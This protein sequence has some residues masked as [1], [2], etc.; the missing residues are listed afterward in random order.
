MPIFPL[1]ALALL[2][3]DGMTASR[4]AVIREAPDFALTTQDNQTLRRADLQGKVLL[5]S[6]VF[7]T[8][9]GT[10]PATTH[11]M[12]QVQDELQRQ[13]LLQEPR[14]HLVSITL[15][16]Q[17]DTPAVLRRYMQLYDANPRNW[18]FLT[19]DPATVTR[20]FTAWGMWVKTAPD[21]QLDHPSRIFLVDQQGRIR[22]VYNL[23][24]LKT[25]WV[26]DDVKLLL[27]EGKP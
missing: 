12:A 7:T 5:V 4:L 21:N 18:S 11:R 3:A 15:D 10:C 2:P 8:C 14:V 26:V 24:F 25:A 17:R 19:G 9:N 20:V 1:L 22:E 27:S 23:S 6:F 13:G 16:P